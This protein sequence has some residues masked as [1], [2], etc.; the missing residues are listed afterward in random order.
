MKTATLET[1]THVQLRV[2]SVAVATKPLRAVEFDATTAKTN[3]ASA[4]L[5]KKIV[6]WENKP[7]NI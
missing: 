5:G 3:V 7:V 6:V 1:T 4:D 2:V